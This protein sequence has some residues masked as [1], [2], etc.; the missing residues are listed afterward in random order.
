MRISIVLFGVVIL[1]L[2]AGVVPVGKGL[3]A[4]AVYYSPIMILALGLL[5]A[6]CVKCCMRRR[7]VGFFLVH[8]GIV[9]IL[10]GAFVGY[11]LGTKGRVQLPLNQPSAV[12][13]LMGD[14]PESFGFEVAAKDFEVE[15]YPPVYHLYRKL[16]PEQVTPGTMPFEKVDEFNTAGRKFIEFDGGVRVAVSNLKDDVSGDW[17]PMQMLDD[18]KFL[19]LAAQTPSFY[20]VT[21]VVSDR[22]KELELPVS[23]NHPAGY[24]GWRFYLTSYDQRNRSYVILSARRDPG[25]NAV[26]AGIW[27]V[28]VGTFVFCFRKAGGA[29]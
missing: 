23:I 17:M 1:L 14:A 21:L 7:S 2:L 11:L 8:L 9:V 26:I 24:R 29:V 18:N 6:A 13:G 4:S 28:I 27:M 19:H 5:S 20:G 12:S 22:G 25:R 16:P 15:F 10:A 3:S